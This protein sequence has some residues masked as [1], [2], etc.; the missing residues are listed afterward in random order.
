MSHKIAWEK[1]RAENSTVAQ[2]EGMEHC[3]EQAEQQ[4]L[5]PE[6]M[7]EVVFHVNGVPDYAPALIFADSNG[8]RVIISQQGIQRMYARPRVAGAA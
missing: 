5:L 1:Y 3:M 6:Q 4:Q 2:T 8:D 7:T